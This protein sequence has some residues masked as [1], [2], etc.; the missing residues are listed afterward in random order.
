MV[1][2]TKPR[3][4]SRNFVLV[5]TSALLMFFAFFMLV[6]VLPFYL[7]QGLGA[8][9]A[10]AGI[11]LSLYT[12]AGV[13]IRPFSGFMVDK[14]SRK[15]FFLL[16]Y[17]V[18]TVVFAGYVWGGTLFLFALLRVVHGMF[19]GTCSVSSSTLAIDVLPSE[20]RGEGI[21]YF[22]VA[23]N[24]AMAIG[25][26]TGLMLYESWHSFE[27]LFWVACAISAVGWGI[28]WAIRSPERPPC[29]APVGVVSLDRFVLLKGLSLA[30]ALC[31]IGVGYGVVMN[32]IGLYGVQMGYGRGSGLFFMIQAAG[33]IGARI[34]AAQAVDR[35]KIAQMGYMGLGFVALGYGLFSMVHFESVYYLCA[36]LLGL[37]YG[38]IIPAFQTMFVQMAPHSRRGTAMSTYYISWDVGIGVGIAMGGWLIKGIGFY[39]LFALC[40]VVVVLGT[41][42]FWRVG[43]RHFNTYRLR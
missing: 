31:S 35:G 42:H 14:F 18:L 24:I 2:Q 29:D 40:G 30:P 8:T 13:L 5:F 43:V 6:P 37:G 39:W 1:T 10:V 34:F 15:P 22:G 33:I 4:W 28:T 9:E 23:S 12:V 21:G 16:C 36:L 19:Y 32:Y 41:A 3:L 25:P 17:G 38:Y 11:I 27:L 26:M 7:M 20:R